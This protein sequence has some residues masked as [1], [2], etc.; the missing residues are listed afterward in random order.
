MARVL[1]TGFEFP[2]TATASGSGTRAVSVNDEVPA[3]L[4]ICDVDV[5]GDRLLLA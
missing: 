5:D 4:E 1:Q 3:S 2:G